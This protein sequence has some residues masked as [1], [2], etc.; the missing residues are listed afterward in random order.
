MH[1]HD[2]FASQLKKQPSDQFYRLEAFSKKFSQFL[3]DDL[4]ERRI[5]IDDFQGR[6]MVEFYNQHL[7]AA[8]AYLLLVECN[9]V[10]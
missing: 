1:T 3:V 2:L 9:E 10:G 8:F 7:A 4:I 5:V 6:E